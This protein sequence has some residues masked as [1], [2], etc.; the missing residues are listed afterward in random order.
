MN[1][2]PHYQGEL[3][4]PGADPASAIAPPVWEPR[5]AIVRG[6][7]SDL[8]KPDSATALTPMALLR[9]LRRRQLLALGVAILLAITGGLAAFRFVPAKYK[10]QARLHV[11]AQPP[12]VSLLFQTVESQEGGADYRRY[13]STQQQIISSAMV[14]NTA[15]QDKKVSR[16]RM[17]REQIDPVGW[18]KDQLKVDFVSGSEIMEISLSG[19][20]PDEIAGVINAVKKAYMDEVVNFD[21]KLRSERHVKLRNIKERYAAALKEHRASLK[22]LAKK[23]GSDD[24]G[25]LALKQQLEMEHLH[26]V[27]GELFAIQRDKRKTEALIKALRAREEPTETSDQSI[28]EEEIDRFVE[29]QP[30]I[31]SLV[32]KLAQVEERLASEEAHV[33]NVARHATRDP[34]LKHLKD[35]AAALKKAIDRKRAQLRPVAIQELQKKTTRGQSTRLA[36][37][38][39]DLQLLAD[40]EQNLVREVKELKIGGQ[41]LTT[42]TLDIEARQ[43]EV[44]QMGDASSKIGAEIEGLNVELDAPPRVRSIE[45]AIPPVTK[46]EKKRWAI[47]GMVAFGSFFGGLFGIAFLELQSRKVD[48]ADE[49]PMELGLHVMGALPLLSA[50]PTR[51]SRLKLKNKDRYGYDLLLESIDAT[52]TMLVHAAHTGSFRVVMITSAVGGEGKTSL[53]SYLAP[54]LARSGLKTL[55]IDADFRSPS[56]HRIFDVPLGPGLS[57]LLRGEVDSAQVI[58]AT[59]V[60]DLKIVTAGTCDRQTLSLLAQGRLGSHFARFKEQFDFVIVD[61]SPVLPVADASIIA[62]QVDAVL[63][64]I[65][66]EVSRKTGVQAAS[67]RLQCLGV[68]ILGAVVTGANGSHYG[69]YY[70]GSASKYVSLPDSAAKTPDPE[71]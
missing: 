57:E 6:L 60:E 28:P 14:L 35:D 61:S 4:V 39:Q 26:T 54:S 40:I 42:D 46:D 22:D 24:R 71:L 7:P 23:A 55:L 59:A 69:S 17:I 41:E 49:V 27:Q 50:K 21:K 3:A 1:Q 25:T 5:R 20:D 16:Y 36:D 8:G 34:S 45:D 11:S 32:Q 56:L 68:P 43:E 37:A 52:R 62:Q 31:G 2:E 48:T 10:A 18:L 53:A 29:A 33:R 65:F 30:S 15:L 70:G 19:D 47:I 58:G 13:Q 38:E 67:Q 63:F 64:S 44:A 12:K 9:A 51:G 66:R